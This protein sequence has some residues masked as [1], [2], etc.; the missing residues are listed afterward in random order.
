[1]EYDLTVNIDPDMLRDLLDFGYNLC[2]AKKVNDAYTVVWQGS[3]VLLA[4]KFAW[5]SQHEVFGTRSFV[6]GALVRASTNEEPISGGQTAVLDKYGIVN[7]A[8]GTA[9][10]SGK[11]MVQNN[12]GLINLGVNALMNGSHSPTYVSLKPYVSGTITLQPVETILVWLSNEVKTGTM[13]LEAS[14][15]SIEI[16]FTYNS[17]H[18]L[19]YR[20][21]D[22]IPGRGIWVLDERE[23]VL[24]MTYRLTSNSFDIPEPT[25]G[26]LALVAEVMNASAWPCPTPLIPVVAEV[27]YE[28]EWEAR[29][30]HEYIAQNVPTGFAKW[31]VAQIAKSVS[32][33]MEAEFGDDEG[34]IIRFSAEAFVRLL[35]AFSNPNYKLFTMT[36]HGRPAGAKSQVDQARTTGAVVVRF[37]NAGQAAA[38]AD[39]V[40]AMACPAVGFT[41][42]VKGQTVTVRL[43]DKGGKKGAHKRMRRAFDATIAA[44]ESVPEGAE[45]IHVGAITWGM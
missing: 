31:D 35:Y 14:S 12:Y 15:L 20:A 23:A 29:A 9:D 24:P 22:G 18:T 6:S 32:V 2:I 28:T 25:A 37:A 39:H 3:S 45:A 42:F 27:E 5:T 16:D 13:L 34:A 43:L 44:F 17:S 7:E 8:S 21:A 38:F 33:I 41:S 19:R 30:F 36:V 40:E 1:M 4:D 10:D 11:F 26:Q